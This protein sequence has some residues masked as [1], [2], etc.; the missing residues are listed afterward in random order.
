VLY[1][2]LRRFENITGC[3]DELKAHRLTKAY[4]SCSFS[5][6]HS[7]THGGRSAFRT[8]YDH[9]LQNYSLSASSR[10]ELDCH[11]G[12]SSSSKQHSQMPSRTHRRVWYI[13]RAFDLPWLKPLPRVYDTIQ[14]RSTAGSLPPRSLISTQVF[15]VFTSISCRSAALTPM[16]E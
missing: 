1:L 11:S 4:K 8:F 9:T 13:F 7:H 12:T 5:S 3:S 16:I 10:H 14:D 15:P 2:W 6:S